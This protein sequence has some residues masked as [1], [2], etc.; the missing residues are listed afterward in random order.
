MD[1]C[2]DVLQDSYGLDFRLHPVLFLRDRHHL[3]PRTI[4]LGS[5]N[6]ETAASAATVAFIAATAAIAIAE[7]YVNSTLLLPLRFRTPQHLHRRTRPHHRT[8]LRRRRGCTRARQVA[9][10][11]PQIVTV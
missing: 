6:R 7:A 3:P 11:S 1:G 4:P 8:P 5:P 10:T 9:A 2:A